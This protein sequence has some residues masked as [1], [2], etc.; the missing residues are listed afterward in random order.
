MHLQNFEDDWPDADT[1]VDLEI[2]RKYLR[3]SREKN[4]NAM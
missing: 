1:A 4:Y 3:G 2:V